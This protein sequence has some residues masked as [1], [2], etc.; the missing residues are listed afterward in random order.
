M[1]K[2]IKMFVALCWIA[3]L[4]LLFKFAYGATFGTDTFGTGLFGTGTSTTSVYTP[5][6]ERKQII[7]GGIVMLPEDMRYKGDWIIYDKLMLREEEEK[8]EKSLD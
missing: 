5:T 6:N 7:G 4:S 2:W 3:G 1:N 8:W